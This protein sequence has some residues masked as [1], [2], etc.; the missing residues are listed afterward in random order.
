MISKR[1]WLIG[2]VV[3]LILLNLVF[4]LV[5]RRSPETTAAPGG[6][7]L[8]VA[9]PIQNLVHRGISRSRQTWRRYFS[10]VAA[11]EEN[12]RFRAELADLRSQMHRCV[13]IELENRRLRRLLAF[14]TRLAPPAVAAEIIG[15][16]PSP[17][18]RSV[19][20]DKGEAQGVRR[21][22]PVVV[23][24][25][26]VGVVTD[27]A[28]HYARVLLIVDRNSSVDALVQDGRARGMV[29]GNSDSTL[30][31]AYVLRRDDVP[32]SGTVVTSGL[33]G[34]YP[35]GLRIGLV[36][37]VEPHGAGIFQRITVEPFV[38]FETIEEVLVVLTP[39]QD[40]LGE[41]PP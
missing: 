41:P 11:G 21:G 1:A 34:I 5:S 36:G 20:I 31:F 9:G 2:A 39:F 37:E 8:S 22:L 18:F 15:R 19:T 14:R 7:A 26:V 13:E 25:G 3:L 35:K 24:E 17:W 4:V 38:D 30:S 27:T 10:R 29:K 16:D 6:F 23:S 28:R 32:P 40:I 12:E 33:D